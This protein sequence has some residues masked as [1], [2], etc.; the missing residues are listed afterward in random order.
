MPETVYADYV[1]AKISLL[2]ERHWY[3]SNLDRGYIERCWID[4]MDP[5]KVINEL[6]NVIKEQS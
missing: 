5:D 3:P 1:K 2:L 6:M 4:G